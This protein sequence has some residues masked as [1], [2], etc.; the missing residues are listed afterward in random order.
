MLARLVDRGL[1]VEAIASTLGV[2]LNDL[3]RRL[4]RLRL[5]LDEE[6]IAAGRKGMRGSG[7][8]SR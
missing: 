3:H 7:S 8:S 5:V 4:L 6:V 2:D 1:D